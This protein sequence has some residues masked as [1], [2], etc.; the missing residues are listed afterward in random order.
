MTEHRYGRLPRAFMP[1]VPHL[2]A[3][4]MMRGTELPALPQKVDNALGLPP[5]L[6]VMLNDRLGDCTCAGL[7]HAIQVWSQ[8]AQGTMLTEPDA[9][10]LRAYEES[11]GYH[12]DLPESDRGGVEQDVL[13]WAAASGVPMADGSRSKLAAFVEVDPRN[14]ADVCEAI[15]QC[16]LIYI[17]FEVPKLLPEEP[18]FLWSGKNDLG[19]IEGGHCVILTGF[20]NPADPSFD[21]ISWGDRYTMDASFWRKYVDEAYALASLLWIERS[22]GETPWGIDL[23]ALEALMQAIRGNPA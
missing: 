20:S 22:A 1:E 9:L 5:N 2:S 18:G 14:L 17:G 12:P 11:C 3:L 23:A 19:P 7:Y 13:S 21:V 6:G 15:W 4:K 16:G 10:V 8:D